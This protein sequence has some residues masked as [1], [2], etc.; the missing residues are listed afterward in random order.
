MDRASLALVGSAAELRE[1]RERDYFFIVS[2]SVW[3]LWCGI[4]LAAVW[5]D[6]ANRLRDRSPQIRDANLAAAPVLAIAILPLLLNWGWASRRGDYAARDW[7]H[8]LLMSVEPYGILYTNGDNDTFPLWYLQEVEGIRRDV[9]V[10]VMS[11]LNTP[12]YV[13]QI[14][15]LT[16]PC[17]PGEDPLA[18]PTVILCQRPFQPEQVPDF[19]ADAMVSTDAPGVTIASIP[20]GRRAPERTI[21]PLSD[22]EIRSIANQPPYYLDRSQVFTAGQIQATLPPGTVV[23]PADAFMALMIK[24]A[25]NDRPIYYAMTTQAYEDLAL[26]PF[27][28]RQGVAFKLSNGPVQPDSTR[29]IFA[30]S[31]VDVQDLIGPYLDLPRTNRLVDSVFVHRGGFPDEWGRWVDSA[32][33]GIP[34]YYAYTHFG[35]A[36]VLERLGDTMQARIHADRGE[37]CLRLGGMRRQRF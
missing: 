23:I 5:R 25:I 14:R 35:L 16:R 22:E 8:N 27:L 20:P 11:Y 12:W 13:R 19:Y 6:L 28:I 1:V 37:A 17:G 21:V 29:G 32:T 4:G 33:E 15:E 30:T 31:Q 34:F 26:R 3:G 18:D 10:M 36:L 24:E 9:T 2:F 7:A